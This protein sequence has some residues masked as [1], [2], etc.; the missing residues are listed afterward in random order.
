MTKLPKFT[1]L[2]DAFDTLLAHGG[3]GSESSGGSAG[4]SQTSKLTQAQLA[5]NQPVRVVMGHVWLMSP[6]SQDP[7]NLPEH[8]QKLAQ[9]EWYYDIKLP[10]TF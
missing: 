6:P 7:F 5:A 3:G 4:T 8:V 10:S 9:N 2:P 1:Q